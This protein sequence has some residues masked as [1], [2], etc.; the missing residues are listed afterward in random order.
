MGGGP[1]GLSRY[2][3]PVD[4]IQSIPCP[5]VT[6]ATLIHFKC[7]VPWHWCR[8][9]RGSCKM[10]TPCYFVQTQLHCHFVIYFC[11]K[12]I[13]SHVGK[14]CEPGMCTG[15]EEDKS[16]WFIWML[17]L[18]RLVILFSLVQFNA[19]FKTKKMHIAHETAICLNP[20][21]RSFMGDRKFLTDPPQTNSYVC[22]VFTKMWGEAIF[23]MDTTF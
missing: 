3:L 15:L 23:L 20:L 10:I 11:R 8:N 1:C 18:P 9:L 7:A 19:S 14:V 22:Y 6:P 21:I 16:Q 4:V 2:T 12:W 5:N 13:I 17:M